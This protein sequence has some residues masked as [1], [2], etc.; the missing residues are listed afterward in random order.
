MLMKRNVQEAFLR[1]LQKDYFE[2]GSP[3]YFEDCDPRYDVLS[4]TGKFL[5][6]FS[7][8]LYI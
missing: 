2:G 6:F 5:E 1:L 7:S 4:F 8:S 3:R